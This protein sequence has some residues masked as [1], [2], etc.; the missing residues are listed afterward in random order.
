[1]PTTANGYHLTSFNGP[2]TKPMI[3]KGNTVKRKK[4]YRIADA[5]SPFSSACTA[6]CPPHPTHFKPVTAANVHR[7]KYGV[8]SGLKKYKDTIS[9]KNAA[10]IKITTALTITKCRDG[11]VIHPDNTKLHSLLHMHNIRNYPYCRNKKHGN[12]KAAETKH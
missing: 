11:C 3:S 4:L 10:P 5:T 9:S 2:Q 1:M 7:G 6:R 8:V 12:T